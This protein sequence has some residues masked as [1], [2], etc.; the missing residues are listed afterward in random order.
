MESWDA[1]QPG[2]QPGV[3]VSGTNGL[4]SE[5]DLFSET[6]LRSGDVPHNRVALCKLRSGRCSAVKAVRETGWSH[7]VSAGFQ[8]RGCTN[9]FQKKPGVIKFSILKI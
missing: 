2:V 4:R 7:D 3:E 5:S 9:F 8:R 6:N 1:T